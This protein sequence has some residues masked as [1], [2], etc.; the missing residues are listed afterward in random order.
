MLPRLV[1][2]LMAMMALSSAIS[3]VTHI[4]NSELGCQVVGGGW[5]WLEVVG[6]GWVDIYGMV[7]HLAR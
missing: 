7:I 2:E 4:I 6:G 3:S 5:R 1:S